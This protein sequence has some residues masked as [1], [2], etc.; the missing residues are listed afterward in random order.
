[1]VVYIV[2]VPLHGFYK[3]M[4]DRRLKFLHFTV[5]KPKTFGTLLTAELD[6]SEN[7]CFYDLNL[8]RAKCAIIT[9]LQQISVNTDFQQ[10]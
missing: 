3:I 4:L 7:I 5:N 1:M 9:F 10:V 8:S 2:A 6:L